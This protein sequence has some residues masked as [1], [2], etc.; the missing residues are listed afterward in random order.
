LAVTVYQ[1]SLV[2]KGRGNENEEGKK[3]INVNKVWLRW[4]APAVAAQPIRI[5]S[6]MGAFLWCHRN[7]ASGWSARLEW[8]STVQVR[9]LVSYVSGKVQ[10]LELQLPCHLI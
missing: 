4:L 2:T 5:R 6:P 9:F 8:S 3:F 7:L 10:E 1:M